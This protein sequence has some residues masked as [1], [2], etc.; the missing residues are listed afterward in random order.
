M[1]FKVWNIKKREM[2]IMPERDTYPLNKDLFVLNKTLCED[3]LGNTIFENDIVQVKND[4]Q[5]AV[6]LLANSQN[7]DD[8]KTGIIIGD[9]FV[10]LTVSKQFLEKHNLIILKKEDEKAEKKIEKKELSDAEKIEAGI[11][12]TCGNKLVFEDGCKSCKHC[13][14]SLCGI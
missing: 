9:K 11:C 10:G 2:R 5:V 12:P 14:F 7:I 4:L 3:K 6:N 13:G 1:E 8:I